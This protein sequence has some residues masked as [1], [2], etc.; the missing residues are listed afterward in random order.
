M[1]ENAELAKQFLE[2]RGYSIK[3][4]EG[5]NSY[6]FEKQDLLNKPHDMVWA[7]QPVKPDHYIGKEITQEIFIVKNHPLGKIY[8]PQIGFS[9]KVEVSVFIFNDEI[10]G[11]T[12]FP[13]GKGITGA[14]YSLDGLTAEEFLAEDYREWRAKWDEKYGD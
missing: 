6:S 11:G 8:G 10:I 9:S 3:S 4:Y 14:P 7:V 5:R 1:D 2:D 13:I 12:S